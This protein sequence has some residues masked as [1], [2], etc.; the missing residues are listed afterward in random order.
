M[1]LSSWVQV[2][3]LSQ[4]ERSSGRSVRSVMDR[5]PRPTA[6]APDLTSSLMPNGSRTR[7]SASSLSWLPV[8]STVTASRATSTTCARNSATVSRTFDLLSRSARTL[9]RISSRCT[10]WVG[11]S[12][13][14]LSTLMSLLSCL[15]TCSSGCSSQSTTIVIRE[16]SACSVGPTASDSMLNPRRENR[17]AI[18]TSTPGLF[19]T[20]T[21]R[22]CWLS[23][24]A[25]F[26][27]L[28]CDAAGV[29]DVVVAG[30]GRDHRPHHRVL[31][32][33]EVD[34][35][36]LV[37]DRHRLL[38]DRV[39]VLLALAAQADAAVGLRQLHEVGDP[40]APQLGLPVT[41]VGVGVPLVVEEGL[42]LA[43]HAE[44]AV[45]DDRDLDRDSL[46]RAGGKLL[47]GHLEAA[48]AVDRPH[49]RLGQAD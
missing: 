18:R 43:D 9:I 5:P 16:I 25:V 15:V 12:S 47:V 49:R 36:R 22:V 13:T 26:L 32:H 38:D 19:S 2:G 39:H 42:P 28:R 46:D 45:V 30:A 23:L 31:V 27:P 44:V 1:A 48:V 7:T 3:K 29:A 41:Q 17:P 4:A 14:I 33:D 34:H 8:A 37:V 10:A 24:I 35:D 6:I 21:D 40:G 11:S 20:R